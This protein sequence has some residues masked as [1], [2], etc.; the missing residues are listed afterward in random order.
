[1]KVMI[2]FLIVFGF[3]AFAEDGKCGS[4]SYAETK[5][6]KEKAVM[7]FT[8]NGQPIASWTEENGSAYVEPACL[9]VNNTFYLFTVWAEGA[10]TEVVRIFNPLNKSKVQVY[11]LAADHIDDYKVENNA[12]TVFYKYRKENKDGESEIADGEIKPKL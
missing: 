9:E 3:K 10:H 7:Q 11:E 2:V 5:D 1:M 4:W 12:L 8:K 6:N